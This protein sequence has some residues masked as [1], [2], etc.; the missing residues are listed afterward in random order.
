MRLAFLDYQITVG[1]LPRLTIPQEVE[2]IRR[3]RLCFRCLALD[4]QVGDGELHVVT[5]LQ[6]VNVC[7]DDQQLRAFHPI[8]ERPALVV[9]NAFAEVIQH[10]AN[11]VQ[12]RNV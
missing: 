4:R 11:L 5:A 10:G 12:S 7:Y 3:P 9:L 8:L 1:R 2:V 6:A